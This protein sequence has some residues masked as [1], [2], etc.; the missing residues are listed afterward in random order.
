MTCHVSPDS[1]V[2]P[3]L[4]ARTAAAAPLFALLLLLAPTPSPAMCFVT[5]N[6]SEG[7][8]ADPAAARTTLCWNPA[9]PVPA[10]YDI[11]HVLWNPGLGEYLAVGAGGAILASPDGV[12]WTPR[13]S[14]TIQRLYGGIW[15]GQR[16][17]VVGDGGTVLTSSADGMAWTGQVTNTRARLLD[18]A[19][20]DAGRYVVVGED[21][22]AL[23][24]D[25]T[26]E[27]TVTTALGLVRRP[28]LYGV[29][30]RGNRFVAVGSSTAIVSSTNGLDWTEHSYVTLPSQPV[31][32]RDVAVSTSGV[33]VAVGGNGAVYTSNNGNDWNPA[34]PITEVPDAR[35]RRVAWISGTGLNYFLATGDDGSADDP[36][37][38]QSFDTGINWSNIS[39][40]L[41]GSATP[42]TLKAIA[43]SGAG[44]VLGGNRSLLQSPN[45]ALDWQTVSPD[46]PD[47]VADLNDL[48]SPAFPPGR[49]HLAV[50]AG[51]AVLS[52]ADGLTWQREISGSN[53]MLR[54]IA[55]RR[56]D[57]GVADRVVVVGDAGT[58]L[59]SDDGAVWATA[60]SG[61]TADLTDAAFGVAT[62]VAVG[63]GGSLLSSPDGIAWTAHD[64]GA[65]IDLHGV[66]FGQVNDAAGFVA[67]GSGGAVLYSADG[68]AW[69]AVNPAL[70]GALRAV[71][72]NDDDPSPRFVAVGETAGAS[73]TAA[74]FY[75]D[76]GA[77]WTTATVPA[78]QG[79]GQAVPP[80]RAVAWNGRQF[81]AASDGD[82][83]LRSASGQGWTAIGNAPIE[84]IPRIDALA[85]TGDRFL[86]AGAGGRIGGSGG[87]DLVVGVDTDVS[88]SEND[89]PAFANAGVDKRYRFTVSNI[90]NLDAT[91]VIFTYTP[92][93]G[94]SGLAPATAPAG[95]TCTPPDDDTGLSCS[96]GRLAAGDD[97]AVIIEVVMTMPENTNITITHNVA[98]TTD[99]ADGQPANNSLAV[100]TRI[101][102]LPAPG[103]PSPDTDFGGRGAFGSL[104]MPSLL[105]LVL[106]GGF[107]H[108]LSSRPR[109]AATPRP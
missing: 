104:D 98:V 106:F 43:Y 29:V 18:A 82:T 6:F 99:P 22:T 23:A 10:A 91:G 17:I 90:G 95:W 61:V 30:A 63:A 16:Y 46:H 76:D 56:D 79:A 57:A 14:G 59:Y 42:T 40:S 2:A 33:Y 103:L 80:L 75:S 12:E 86:A 51:G 72:W 13:D 108:L 4:P 67:V 66:A 26:V 65:G 109:T 41:P 15:D 68:A 19:V 105:L 70:T 54:G 85:W 24:S 20:N 44:L 1:R 49:S 64:G 9:N 11:E 36:L 60:S 39:S 71:V 97:E 50:G 94:I 3:T 81:I 74:A 37:L 8:P 47:L 89:S 102:S 48:V 52:S 28:A 93:A 88:I 100:A 92:P 78:P 7:E 96:I 101:G 34:P 73:P 69:T 5:G 83:F 87:V 84:T 53:T 35:L 107:F 77:A 31:V 38:L 45:T 32:L 55:A 58:V 25:D 27:W 21:G 62:F